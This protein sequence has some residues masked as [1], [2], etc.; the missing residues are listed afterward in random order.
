MKAKPMS[1]RKLEIPVFAINLPGHYPEGDAPSM[2]FKA[3]NLARMAS[4]GLPVPPALVLGTQACRLHSQLG[5]ELEPLLAPLLKEKLPALE[6]A[7]QR[8]LGSPRRPLLLSVRSGAPIS[9]PGM[10][11]TLLNIGLTHAT[12]PGLLRQTGNP[13]LVWDSYR[14]LIQQYGEVVLGLERQPFQEAEAQVKAGAGVERTRDLDF[15]GLRQLAYRNLDIYRELAREEFPQHPEI[16]L[17][18]AI[19]AVFSSWQSARAREYRQL[20]HLDDTLGTA[21]TLQQMVF[22]NG[23]GTSGSGVG[24]TRDPATGANQRFIDFLF[25]CQGEDVVSG[26]HNAEDRERLEKSFPSL[27]QQLEGIC[28]DLEQHFGDMQEFEFTLQNGQLYLLQT[29]TGKRTPWAALQIAVDQV[30]AGLIS[31]QEGL[32]RLAEVDLKHLERR[33]LVAGQDAQPLA[34]AESA[35]VGL[36]SGP[37]A[38]DVAMARRLASEGH[39]PILVR[40]EVVTED[41]GGLAVANGVLTRCGGRT[42]HAAV[43]ARQMGKVCLM[44][45]SAMVLDMT[46]RQALFGETRVAE[47]QILTLDA[48]EGRVFLGTPQQKTER[49]TALLK[50]VKQWP[51]ALPPREPDHHHAAHAHRH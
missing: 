6:A 29:R 11:D 40:E 18:K 38:L 36:A 30:E 3:Y 37:L 17:E 23:G 7:T 28:Q 49:P 33:H 34:T 48:N 8:Q 35:S 44:G 12:V 32:E 47:G 2:G 39:A 14:R 13:R 51:S 41:I 16:Q 20:H 26:R 10:M 42:A 50:I 5:R 25:N 9:M 22:G 19:M 43:V 27:W 46:Q 15:E 1:A 31:P 4:F 21:V 24:F 45:C